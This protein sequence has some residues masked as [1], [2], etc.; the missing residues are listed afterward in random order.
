[1]FL[2]LTPRSFNLLHSGENFRRQTIYQ[3]QLLPRMSGFKV[4]GGKARKR[5]QQAATAVRRVQTHHSRVLSAWGRFQ[6]Q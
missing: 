3:V 6:R 4:L 1:M 5:L 2:V